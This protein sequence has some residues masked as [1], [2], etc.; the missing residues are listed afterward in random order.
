MAGRMDNRGAGSVSLRRLED[1][2]ADSST[3]PQGWSVVPLSQ[4]TLPTES[5]NP[6]AK[7]D[8]LFSYVDVSSISSVSLTIQSPTKLTGRD[9]PS[10]ARKRIRAGDVLFATVRPTLKRVALVPTELDG[11]VCSTA[12]CV[13]RSNPRIADAA[14][15]FFAVSSDAFLRTLAPNERGMSYP[16][17]TDKLVL[18]QRVALPPVPQ[19]REIGRVLSAV[20]D[21]F[22]ATGQVI[23]AAQRLK[24]S[25]S[26]ALIP[27]PDSFFPSPEWKV[28]P[29]S[30]LLNGALRAGI[31]ARAC[32]PEMGV[33]TF[34]LSAVTEDSFTVENTKYTAIPAEKLGSVWA[35][36]GDIFV[37]RANTR[38]LVGSAALFEGPSK[39]A[40]FPDLFV[41]VSVRPT[42]VNRRFLVEYLRSPWAR[43]YFRKRAHPTAGDMPKISHGTIGGIPVPL[44]P[45]LEQE[46]IASRLAAI[47]Q[48]IMSEKSRS[49]ALRQL[50]DSLLQG[51]M[52]GELRAPSPEAAVNA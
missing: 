5:V 47:D 50:S 39:F 8:E 17:V 2:L 34:T 20:R 46:R 19:Q 52:C 16:A 9:A 10:R 11:Q 3:L 24:R 18:Q 27:V 22:L 28:V 37:E 33:R 21:A 29:L 31:S 15:L 36:E 44:A 25:M 6:S 38:E 1:P 35:A 43:S 41:R 23:E 12:F 30:D 32:E 51:L 26:A 7:P 4:L 13:I 48:K 49:T 42:L 14:F 45:M 40:A